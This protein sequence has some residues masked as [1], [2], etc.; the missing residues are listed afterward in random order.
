MS[1][2]YGFVKQFEQT[3]FDHFELE[4]SLVKKMVRTLSS[5]NR[6]HIVD[7]TAEWDQDGTCSLRNVAEELSEAN[8]LFS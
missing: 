7:D 3:L 4:Y 8:L 6:M 2:P 5:F 1:V